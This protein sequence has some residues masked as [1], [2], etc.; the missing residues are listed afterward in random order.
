[1][2]LEEVRT[3]VEDIGDRLRRNARGCTLFRILPS[4]FSPPHFLFS[5]FLLPHRLPT[6]RIH[7]VRNIPRS[8]PRRYLPF[9]FVRVGDGDI[10]RE[11]TDVARSRSHGPARFAK[12]GWRV[13]EKPAP[14]TPVRGARKARHCYT[15]TS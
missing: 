12:V 7:P 2:R 8:D 13:C 3:G 10:L 9:P 11:S 5:F 4:S 14:L 6:S 1:M 15:A